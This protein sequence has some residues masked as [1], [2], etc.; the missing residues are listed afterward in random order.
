MLTYWLLNLQFL[1]VAVLV[2]LVSLLARRAP[3]GRAV[4]GAAVITLVL[5][6][7]FDNVLVGTG[8]V[9]YDVALTSRW[10]IGVAPI[11]DF[12]YAFGAIVL[13]PALWA[14]LGGPR[15]SVYTPPEEGEA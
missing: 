11:E 4:G 8:I 5:T 1:T 9:A 10:T 12:A 15:A 13:L 7:S 3:S 6:A 2:L 14:M